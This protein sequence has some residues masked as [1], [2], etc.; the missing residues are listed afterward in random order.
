M[1]PGNREALLSVRLQGGLRF[2]PCPLPT[3][4]SARVAAS[5][6]GGG[7]TGYPIP[8]RYPSGSGHVSQLVA[9]HLRQKNA[10]PLYLT[11]HI[12][13]QAPQHLRIR[14]GLLN[15]TACND[16]SLWSTRPLTPVPRPPCC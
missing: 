7:T 11:T 16:A 6:P 2:L 14:S 1:R 15:I 12:L 9:Q 8:H 13:V 4:P 5:I 3:A 10:E